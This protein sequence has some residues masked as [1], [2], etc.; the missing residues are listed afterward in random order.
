MPNSIA[1]E[2]AKNGSKKE[3]GEER[4]KLRNAFARRATLEELRIL[5][6]V[7]ECRSFK[8]VA[9]TF[10]LSPPAVSKKVARIEE[11]LG[12]PIV[13]RRKQGVIG[14]TDWGEMLIGRAREVLEKFDAMAALVGA[15]SRHTRLHVGLQ[16]DMT[17]P[18]FLEGVAELNQALPTTQ[19]SVTASLSEQLI[20]GLGNR[21]FDVALLTVLETASAST[22]KA[23]PACDWTELAVEP[24]C[25]VANRRL[26]LADLDSVP[27]ALH[28]DGCVFRNAARLALSAI[29]KSHWVAFNG[30]VHSVRGAVQ[31]GIGIG[32]MR[33]A[34]CGD[35]GVILSAEDGFPPLQ[36][37]H[38]LRAVRRDVQDR[39]AADRVA[40]VLEAAWRRSNPPL[41]ESQ[42]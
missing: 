36:N 29:N 23:M 17:G 13:R 20:G 31:R 38:L 11:L 40:Q 30:D 19:L 4:S 7:A 3:K 5:V 39:D 27:L 42:V 34:D 15:P 37:V 16:A 24:L 25:W 6:A 1:S 33:R 32:V 12:A 41:A 22:M 21:E 26:S 28:P 35:E 10:H 9:D 18:L 8:L 14:L 2:T